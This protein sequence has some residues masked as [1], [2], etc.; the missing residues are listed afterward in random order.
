MS[1]KSR[2][3]SIPSIKIT[4]EFLK[5]FGEIV[6][7]EIRIRENES[8]ERIQKEIEKETIEIQSRDYLSDEEKKQR[9]EDSKKHIR[10]MNKPFYRLDLT[11]NSPNETLEFSSFKDLL[12][13]AFFPSN[14]K[15]MSLWLEHYDYKYVNMHIL[16]TNDGDSYFELSSENEPSLLKFKKD[17]EDLFKEFG[18]TYGWLYKYHYIPLLLTSWFLTGVLIFLMTLKTNAHIGS[19]GLALSAAIIDMILIYAIFSVYPTI[20]FKINKKHTT[21]ET[22]RKIFWMIIVT[23]IAGGLFSLLF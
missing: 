7:R 10:Q 8:N 22:L 17:L 11:I 12:N 18:T 20:E 13:N 5:K 23:F 16:F 2:K 9:I 6:E 14:I 15:R 19:L 21:S 3:V 1:V 4:T